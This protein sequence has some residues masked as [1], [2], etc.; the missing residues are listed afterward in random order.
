MEDEREVLPDERAFVN[1]L[2]D[3]HAEFSQIHFYSRRTLRCGIA[4][5][6]RSAPLARPNGGS[7]PSAEALPPG[8]PVSAR[9]R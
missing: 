4:L 5:L 3:H 1:W 8:E 9:R 2:L 6:Q 7:S